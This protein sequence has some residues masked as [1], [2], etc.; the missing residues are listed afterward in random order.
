MK[1]APFNLLLETAYR[2]NILVL[3][4]NCSTA[5]IFCSHLQNPREVDAYYIDE[6]TREQIET[7]IEFL[8]EGRKIIIG[9]SATRICEGEPFLR[10]DIIEI[11][12]SN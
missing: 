10:E 3:T 9:E 7:Q 6:L 2:D 5:C 1:P 8:D 11:L 4:T 12:K